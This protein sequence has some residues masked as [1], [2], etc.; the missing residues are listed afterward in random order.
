[1]I[2]ECIHLN[3]CARQLG[4]HLEALQTH[5]DSHTSSIT[6]KCKSLS[7]QW[8]LVLDANQPACMPQTAHQAHSESCAII[9]HCS[10]VSLL[11]S[12]GIRA[13]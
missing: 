3:G 2:C 12:A 13:V 1:M 10:P 9:G 6:R 7:K 11:R 5:I 4:L 8:T